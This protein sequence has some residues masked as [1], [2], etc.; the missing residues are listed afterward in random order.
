VALLLALGGFLFGGKTCVENQNVVKL[1]TA[2]APRRPGPRR[3]ALDL[4]PLAG[5]GGAAA[6]GAFDAASLDHVIREV[7]GGKVK[8]EPDAVATPAA[9][10][11]ADPRE[12]VGKTFEVTGTVKAID[13]EVFK[14]AG[15][16]LYDQLWAFALEGE[17][18]KRVVVVQPGLSNNFE[19]DKPGSLERLRRPARRELAT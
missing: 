6:P 8:R 10:V 19:G 17:D 12:A 9:V 13:K 2:P 11:A 5:P 18:G 7:A 15:S 1:P 3:G 4:G 16:P 14:S